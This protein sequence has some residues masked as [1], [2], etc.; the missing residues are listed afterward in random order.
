M[1]LDLIPEKVYAEIKSILL[2][3]PSIG[4]EDALAISLVRW[5]KFDFMTWVDPVKCPQCGGT[6]KGR[7][8]L[9]GGDV[10]EEERQGGAARVELYQCVEAQ[11]DGEEGCG[12]MRRFP[13]YK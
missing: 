6:T 4:A 1:A 3:D 10:N 13:R 2:K 7:G 5:F 12:G 8:V 9:Q 11:L